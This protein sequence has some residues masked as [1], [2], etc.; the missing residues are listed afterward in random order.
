M[1]V[2]I[3][4]AY[5]DTSTRVWSFI[6]KSWLANISPANRQ[7]FDT[8]IFLEPCSMTQQDGKCSTLFAT[9][10]WGKCVNLIGVNQ[11]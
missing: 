4:S 7:I 10:L 9:D 5:A 6:N 1:P 2:R 8:H 3:A 11:H